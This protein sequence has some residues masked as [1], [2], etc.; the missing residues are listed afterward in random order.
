LLRQSFGFHGPNARPIFGVRAFPESP[1][2]NEGHPSPEKQL[3]RIRRSHDH[4]I[5]RF[6]RLA[7]SVSGA[8]PDFRGRAPPRFNCRTSLSKRESNSSTPMAVRKHYIVESVASGLALFDYNGDGLIDI[9]FLNGRPLPDSR[10]PPSRN[11]LYRNDGNWHFT[12]V[13]EQAAW[14]DRLRAGGV[15]WRL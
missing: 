13:T 4:R 12:D 15:H 6:V 8:R 5:S 7:F 11:A 9:Y 10:D 2:P 14:A 3:K 1:I